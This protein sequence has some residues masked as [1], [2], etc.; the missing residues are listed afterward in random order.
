MSFDVRKYISA[1]SPPDTYAKIIKNTMMNKNIKQ[2]TNNYT[3][4]EYNNLIHYITCN[5]KET[6]YSVPSI[7]M[8]YTKLPINRICIF[9]NGN[10]KDFGLFFKNDNE[11]TNN[12]NIEIFFYDNALSKIRLT[13][14]DINVHFEYLSK[15]ELKII[16]NIDEDYNLENIRSLNVIINNLNMNISEIM[17]MVY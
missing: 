16:I 12:S 6:D 15:I 10:F 2:I 4:R 5:Y 3:Y 8:E 14:D 13:N 9:I 11:L 1:I 17:S 7:N